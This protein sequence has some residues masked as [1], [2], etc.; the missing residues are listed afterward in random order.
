MLIDGMRLLIPKGIRDVCDHYEIAPSLLMLNAWRILMA[1][2]SL[3][4]QH[5]V[6]Y[7]V[8]EVLFSYNL[9]EH[10]TDKGRYQLI[11]RVS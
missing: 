9:K 3:S 7:E 10:D 5:G 2:E 8:G 1:L 11:A 4:I 6:E